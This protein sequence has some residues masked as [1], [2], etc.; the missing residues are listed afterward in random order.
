MIPQTESRQSTQIKIHDLVMDSAD[1]IS[2]VLKGDI[3]TYDK[4]QLLIDVYA[5]LARINMLA[6]MAATYIA[7]EISEM[8]SND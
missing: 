6:T 4:N 8:K 5:N 7:K 3:S 1:K 2:E